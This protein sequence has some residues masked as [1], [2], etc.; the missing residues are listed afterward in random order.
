MREKL[1]LNSE[2]ANVP[3]ALPLPATPVDGRLTKLE[4]VNVVSAV[5]VWPRSDHGVD[6]R[7]RA[8]VAERP[9]C[10]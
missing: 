5:A 2:I 4:L 10:R 3:G 7:H 1:E 8:G 6:D 9:G